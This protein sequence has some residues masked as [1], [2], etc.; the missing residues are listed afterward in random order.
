MSDPVRVTNPGAESLGYLSNGE[1][2]MAIYVNSRPPTIV[3]FNGQPPSWSSFG[4]KTFWGANDFVD[5]SPTKSDIAQR[6]KEINA[7]KAGIDSKLTV[8]ASKLADAKTKL[9]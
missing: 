3:N 5:D 1:E 4:N 9:I 8:N 7:V 2:V 6:D